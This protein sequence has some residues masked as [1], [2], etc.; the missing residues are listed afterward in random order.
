MDRRTI[1][2]IAGIAGAVLFVATFTIEGWL[3]P[4]Y[5]AR[6]MF[7]SELALGPRGVVQIVNFV[8]AGVLTMLF[9]RGLATEFP[10]ARAGVV[11]IRL[12]GL[13]LVGA[14]AFVMDPLTT[15]I[16]ARHWHGILHGVFGALLFFYG[17]PVGTF[18][19]AREFR[20]D[21]RWRPLAPW[22]TAVAAVT[23]ALT[24]VL[25]VV[26]ELQRTG[27]TTTLPGGAIQRT[28]HIVYFVWQAMVAARLLWPRATAAHPLH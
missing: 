26:V 1:G 2:A 12:V 22:T 27:A 25:P 17:M 16:R 6:R 11:A 7:I 5:D 14:G 8:V 28:H 9:A 3:R 4:E 20:R 19:F 10:A 13:G 23:I 18:L 21:P 24:F 15:P